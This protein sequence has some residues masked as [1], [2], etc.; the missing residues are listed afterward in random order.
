MSK[1]KKL[2]TATTAAATARKNN[3]KVANLT[4]LLA[5]FCLL[6]KAS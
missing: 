4:S 5:S 3:D 2:A 6:H 1:S